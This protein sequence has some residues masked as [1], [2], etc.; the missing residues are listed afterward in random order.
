MAVRC[1]GPSGWPSNDTSVPSVER[2]RQ[3]ARTV[4]SI[5]TQPVIPAVY[6]TPGANAP[7]EKVSTLAELYRDVFSGLD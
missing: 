5:G 1:I 4:C 6:V 7:L 2:D 3:N